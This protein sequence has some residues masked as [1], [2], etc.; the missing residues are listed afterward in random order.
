MNAS[1][2]VQPLSGS[3]DRPNSV[4]RTRAS[5]ILPILAVLAL[6]FVLRLP[7][8]DHPFLQDEVWTLQESRELFETTVLP[9]IDARPLYFLLQHALLAV[10]PAN[11]VGLR[12]PPLVFGLLGVWAT[13]FAAS[14]LFSRSV[15]I[16]AAVL[17]AV[18]PWHIWV[19][20]LARY[21]SLVYLLALLAFFGIV[22]SRQTGS[23]RHFLL[24]ALVCFAGVLVHPT[25]LFAVAGAALAVTLV[26]DEGRAGWRWPS[27]S[28]WLY[29]WTPLA[30]AVG[31]EVLVLMST[32]NE[33]SARNFGGRGALATL[34]L[35]PAIVYWL[36]VLM[37]VAGAVGAMALAGN[38]AHRASQRWGAMTLAGSIVIALTLVAASMV[39]DV[40]FT[41]SIY[42]LPLLI[43]SAAAAIQLLGSRTGEWARYTRIALP[44]ILVAGMLPETLSQVTDGSRWDYRPALA[45]IAE[46]DPTREV[47]GWPGVTLAHYAPELSFRF[48][49]ADP[50]WLDEMK[51]DGGFWALASVKREGIAT[52]QGG[53]QAAWLAA[54][55]RLE[56]ETQK[57]R[58][59]YQ[60]FSVELHR[61]GF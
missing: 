34:R 28:E 32:G 5:G 9:G 7:G 35:V 36:T 23:R 53:V 33:T 26:N 55:C 25:F 3:A 48:F 54:N 18:H 40:Y 16:T 24:T 51:A 22:W 56:L 10:L 42:L 14:R 49:K 59:D 29:L 58:F 17:V 37:T 57:M 11:E 43:V 47:V 1:P 52:D 30:L 15:G 61:C 46:I 12:F 41:Y 38:R 20:T 39:T 60:M 27:R 4:P 6:A 45:R 21:W 13:W 50:A 31:I 44:A 19:S 2:A 8:L